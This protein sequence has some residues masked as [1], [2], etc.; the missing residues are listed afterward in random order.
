MADA[1]TS[2]PKD[3]EVNFAHKTQHLQALRTHC[4]TLQNAANGTVSNLREWLKSARD[5][6]VVWDS[7]CAPMG[8]DNADKDEPH[9]AAAKEV[10]K[11]W[12]AGTYDKS[13]FSVGTFPHLIL[14][15]VNL[16]A[17]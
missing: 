12:H 4:V 5:V 8:V 6:S 16:L 9:A 17:V 7:I 14:F 11:G 1:L 2:R 10:S 3:Q 13:A 15:L